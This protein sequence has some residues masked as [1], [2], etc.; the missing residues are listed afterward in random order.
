[1]PLAFVSPGVSLDQALSCATGARKGFR[2]GFVMG[3]AMF[4]FGQYLAAFVGVAS[5]HLALRVLSAPDAL[6]AWVPMLVGAVLLIGFERMAQR[7]SHPAA[8]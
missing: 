5:G 8:R 4:H 6:R 7:R 1:M 3:R 2:L